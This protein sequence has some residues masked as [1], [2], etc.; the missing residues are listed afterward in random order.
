MDRCEGIG[1][2]EKDKDGGKGLSSRGLRRPV[3]GAAK[4]PRQRRYGSMA[5]ERGGGRGGQA[6]AG[7][8]VMM[9]VA[10]DS[11]RPCT[12]CAALPRQV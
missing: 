2:E 10:R 11:H 5:G 4:P 6:A 1:E 7:L 3:C 12:P 8:A 9:G